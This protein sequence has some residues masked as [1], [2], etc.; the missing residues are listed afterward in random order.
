MAR[1]RAWWAVTLVALLIAIPLVSQAAQPFQLDDLQKLVKL[2]DPQ[3]SPD[4]KSVAIVVSTPDW[5][6]DKHDTRIDV[7][8]VTNGAKR[9]L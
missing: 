6:T 9:I 5:K 8:E 4:G 3:L 7:V 1:S 2:S